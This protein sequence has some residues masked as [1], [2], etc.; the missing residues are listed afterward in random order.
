MLYYV[1]IRRSA[2][3]PG[4]FDNITD[5]DVSRYIGKVSGLFKDM[6]KIEETVEGVIYGNLDQ[7]DKKIKEMS[8]SKKP[9]PKGKNAIDKIFL[10]N[11]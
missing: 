3:G 6:S 10:R 11:S 8:E 7:V 2:P 1:L 5:P 9:D 4:K